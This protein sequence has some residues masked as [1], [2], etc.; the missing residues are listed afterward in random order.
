M[1]SIIT[2]LS[3]NSITGL[4]SHS[5]GYVYIRWQAD[6]LTLDNLSDVQRVIY[7][8]SDAFG[9]GLLNFYMLLY[10]NKMTSWWGLKMKYMK[11]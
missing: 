1:T 9:D 3:C 6:M 5:R 7:H 10:E 4:S 8:T 2:A 11:K